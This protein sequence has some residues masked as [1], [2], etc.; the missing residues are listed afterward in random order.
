MEM[1]IEEFV[2]GSDAFHFSYS[3]GDIIAEA[4]AGSDTNIAVRFS[5]DLTAPLNAWTNLAYFPTPPFYDPTNAA[6]SFGI[7]PG[8]TNAVPPLHD[9]TCIVT[10]I[11]TTPQ[12]QVVTNIVYICDHVPPPPDAGF[13]TLALHDDGSEFNGIPRWWL[14][15]YNL[16]SWFTPADAHEDIH[17]LPFSWHAAYHCGIDLGNHLA[18]GGN[19]GGMMMPMGGGDDDFVASDGTPAGDIMKVDVTVQDL[20]LYD[21]AWEL[22][23]TGERF[24]DGDRTACVSE[25]VLSNKDDVTKVATDKIY[26]PVGQTVKFTLRRIETGQYQGT[27]EY[28][29]SFP[30]APLTASAGGV[31]LW[32]ARPDNSPLSGSLPY[33]PNGS[34][35][36]PSHLKW[37]FDATKVDFEF[38]TPRGNP[39][40]REEMNDGTGGSLAGKNQYTYNAESPG[41]VVMVLQ[42]KVTSAPP[43]AMAG[44]FR[45]EADPIPGSVMEWNKAHPG[46][47][48]SVGTD[49]ALTA[50]AFFTGL[51]SQ[52]QHFGL[53]EARLFYNNA[54]VASAQY[55]VYFPKYATNRPSCPTC[56]GCYNWFYYWREGEVCGIP[57]DSMFFEN[58]KYAGQVNPALFGDTIWF[59][60]S[61]GV[62]NFTHTFDSLWPSLYPQVKVGGRGHGIYCAAETV[63]HEQEHLFV[64]NFSPS[65]DTDGDG[66]PDAIE[67]N[68]RGIKTNPSHPDTYKVAIVFDDPDYA[69]IG[70][71][72]IRCLRMEERDDIT[73]YPE[74]DWANPGMQHKNRMGSKDG[75]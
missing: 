13:F 70:D 7:V 50:V 41:R 21:D 47:R 67:D 26:V 46:G 16:L 71:Q 20:D 57:A 29:V 3:A 6:V 18:G 64:Y 25:A 33:G 49:G 44:D 48:P 31:R 15:K 19:G 12:G 5:K 14:Q 75:Q 27:D 39:L 32:A 24:R 10:N 43:A 23:F 73:V 30:A 40:V 45:F 59:G 54:Q 17:G 28:K 42:A 52:N 34:P 38:V 72:E 74:K 62:F 8:Y 51:P 56:S 58:L 11:E 9:S 55:A 36:D 66:I 68:Y 69:I 1:R 37:Q 61:A 2:A 22:L 35:P 60:P 65:P 63:Q 53:K 4:Y